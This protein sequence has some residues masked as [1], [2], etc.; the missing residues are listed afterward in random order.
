MAAPIKS[1]CQKIFGFVVLRLC[2]TLTSF[3]HFTFT[4]TCFNPH[5]KIQN[6]RPPKKKP[7]SLR[8]LRNFEPFLRPPLKKIKKNFLLGGALMFFLALWG[9]IGAPPPPIWGG[10]G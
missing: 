8:N 4:H 1:S 10:G 7:K 6:L 9:Q 2:Y 5:P 3:F